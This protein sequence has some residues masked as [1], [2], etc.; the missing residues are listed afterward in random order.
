[1]DRILSA[2]LLPESFEI[3]AD[4][5]AE[6]WVAPG[7]RVYRASGDTEVVVRYSPRIARWIREKGPVEERD[8]GS[9]LVRHRVADPDWAV[10][11]VL[12]YGTDAEILEPEVC[13]RSVAMLLGRLIA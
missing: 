8:D 13:R 10:R 4:F 2:T 1:M 9:V 3:P 6:E 12:Q 11:H 7:G 5:D